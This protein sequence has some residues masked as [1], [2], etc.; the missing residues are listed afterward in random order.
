LIYLAVYT[1]V[2]NT[3]NPTGDLDIAEGVLYGMTLAFVADEFVKFWKVG[4]NYLEFWNAFNSTLY[5]ILVVS[6]VLRFVALAHSPST[7]DEQRQLYNQLSY[8]F[9]AFAGPMFWM[10]MMLYL[11]TFRFFGAMFVVLRV[12]M[13]ESLIFFALLFVVMAGFFQ[14]F[15]GMAQVDA[16]VPVHRNILQGMVNSIMQSPEFD[17]FQEF[18]FPFGIILYYV[19]NFIVMTGMFTYFVSLRAQLTLSVLLNILIALYNSAYEDISGNATDEYM[20]IFAQKTMQF[21]RAPDE[22]VFIPR[23]CFNWRPYWDRSLISMLAFNLV[24]ILCLVAPF[25]WWMSKKSYARLNDFVM[26]V[27]YSPLLVVTAWVETHQAHRIR[28]NRRRGEED[29]D[30]AQEWE[31]V[32][33]EVNFD[34]DDTWKQ[35]VTESTPDIKVDGCTYEIRELKKQ[36]EALTEMVAALTQEN[37]TSKNAGGSN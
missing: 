32:A 20:A 29:D 14:A 15:I 19:F 6:L 10:R 2:I 25:E 16:D 11:D 34:L 37:V 7:Q 35:Q 12:M 8:N 36:V 1:A 26:A 18:A 3:V 21:V 9:L 17:T 23:T 4:W 13:K 22:N 5:T 31:H 28:H 33:E 27:I 24:E 30:C